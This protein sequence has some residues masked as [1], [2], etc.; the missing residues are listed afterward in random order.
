MFSHSVLGPDHTSFYE[1]FPFCSAVCW[2][3]SQSL[4]R[5][6]LKPGLF[7]KDG[8]RRDAQLCMDSFYVPVLE[9]M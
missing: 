8:S 3:S 6:V 9:V 7:S 4:H 2:V 1:G 5:S